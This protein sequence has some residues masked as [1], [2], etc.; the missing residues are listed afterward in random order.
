[1]VDTYTWQEPVRVPPVA[2]PLLL[3]FSDVRSAGTPAL[4]AGPSSAAREEEAADDLK[5]RQKTSVRIFLQ[6][7]RELSCRY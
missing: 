6:E 3:R 1:M 7:D 4:R 5:Q 2:T